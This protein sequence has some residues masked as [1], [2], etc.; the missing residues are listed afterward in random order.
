MYLILCRIQYFTFYMQNPFPCIVRGV[1][2]VSMLYLGTIGEPK[3]LVSSFYLFTQLFG[4]KDIVKMS[5][6]PSLTFNAQPES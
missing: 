2:V 3:T 6:F 1:P 5:D 4:L